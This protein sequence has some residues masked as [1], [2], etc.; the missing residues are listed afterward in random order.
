MTRHYRILIAA[1]FSL[2]FI[3]LGFSACSGSSLPPMDPV[4]CPPGTTKVDGICVEQK[5]ANYVGC[6]RARA[7]T[8]SQDK[9][10]KLQLEAGYAGASAKTDIEAKDQLEKKYDSVSDA[11]QIEIIKDCFNGA[12]ANGPISPKS[13]TPPTPPA[14][15]TPVSAPAQN[16]PVVCDSCKK[17]DEKAHACVNAHRVTDCNLQHTCNAAHWGDGPG[18]QGEANAAQQAHCWSGRTKC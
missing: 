14:S 2:S 7:A 16:P 5:I 17:W 9:G 12:L 6:I 1:P 13:V 11:A 15:T 3:A 10:N 18:C 4:N 8:L